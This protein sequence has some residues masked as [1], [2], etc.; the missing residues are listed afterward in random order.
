MVVLE[1]ITEGDQVTLTPF[2]FIQRSDL[3]TANKSSV[4]DQEPKQ[5]GNRI[6]EPRQQSN[7][8]DKE[9]TAAEIGT[10]P[11]GVGT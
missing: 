7:E 10:A 5:E 2:R 11:V 1:G 8:S 3:P 4:S 6:A 9:F